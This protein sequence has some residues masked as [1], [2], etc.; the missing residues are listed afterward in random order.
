VAAGEQ[1][2]VGL[3]ERERLLP[4]GDLVDDYS[5]PA[6]GRCEGPGIERC[7]AAYRR[8]M[9]GMSEAEAENAGFSL[10]FTVPINGGS[11]RTESTSWNP[12]TGYLI[13]CYQQASAIVT[14]ATNERTF[15]GRR[16]V[17]AQEGVCTF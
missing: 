13:P 3:C 14:A 10:P 7:K 15:C 12:A 17:A 2:A 1:M 8:G 5:C 16:V 11:S 6:R 4:N 9:R